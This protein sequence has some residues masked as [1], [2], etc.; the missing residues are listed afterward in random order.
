MIGQRYTK[1]RKNIFKA[2]S[3]SKK[4]ITAQEI[5]NSL[6]NND[7]K[8]NLASIYRNLVLMEKSDLIS[9]ILFGEGKKRFELKE[10][11][12]HHHHFFCEN[13]GD[14][15]DIKMNEDKILANIKKTKF[16]IK[17]HKLEFFGLC[18]D[19]Q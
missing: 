14:I 16:L 8:I 7:E 15:E 4:P 1:T 17:E 3:N 12:S 2:L 19:C 11:N 18:P 10:E 6:K 9:V 13:C 5:F